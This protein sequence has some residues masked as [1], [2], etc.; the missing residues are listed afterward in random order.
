MRAVRGGVEQERGKPVRA[1][2]AEEELDVHLLEGG[3]AGV[4]LGE[5]RVGVF[6]SAKVGDEDGVGIRGGKRESGITISIQNIN[7]TKTKTKTATTTTNVP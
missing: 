1:H 5:W 2:D 3:P 6:L 4:Q 7:T